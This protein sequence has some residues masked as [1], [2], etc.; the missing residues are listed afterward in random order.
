MSLLT[1]PHDFERSVLVPRI[2]L[3]L[4]TL[5]LSLIGLVMVFSASTVLAIHNHTNPASYLFDQC[6]FCLVGIVCAVLIAKFLP[7]RFFAGNGLYV[8]VLL[9]IVAILAVWAVG[10]QALGA[11]RWLRVGPLSVQPSEFIKIILVLMAC[12]LVCDV[13]E[14]RMSQSSGFK[15]LLGLVAAPLMVLLITQSD[16]GTSVIIYVSVLVVLWLGELDKRYWFIIILAS[17]ALLVLA[18]IFSSYRSSRF[19]FLNP[20]NDGDNGRAK[21]YQL[22]HSYYALAQGGIAGVGLGNSREKFLYLPES[23]TDFV[24]S[25]IGEEFGLIGA[26]IVIALFVL[27]F[28]CGMRIA[29]GAPDLFGRLCAGSLAFMVAFQACVNIGCAIGVFP[30][31]GKPLPFISSGGS[32]LVSTFIIVGILLSISKASGEGRFAERRGQFMYVQSKRTQRS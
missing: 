28:Y 4:V 21:G 29:Q 9:A 2:G 14:G 5:A 6:K 20:W 30:T 26:C 24:F 18:I 8:L 17:C 23:E 15:R 27:F 19:L 31:T 1:P 22:V 11:Q 12:K 16:L 10:H 13:R 7:Y 25:I 32:S 3:I